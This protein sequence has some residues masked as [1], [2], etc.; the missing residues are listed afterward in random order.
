MVNID[1]LEAQEDVLCDDMGVWKNNG[2]DKAYMIV[3]FESSIVSKVMKC[4]LKDAKLANTHMVKRVYRT[5]THW[6]N[7]SLRKITAFI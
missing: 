6:T 1:H 4:S 3:K 2:T 5:H 7:L